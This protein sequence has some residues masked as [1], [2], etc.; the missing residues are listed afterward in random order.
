MGESNLNLSK[1]REMLLSFA[2]VQTM[3]GWVQVCWDSEGAA[4]PME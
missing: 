2:G 4:T 3:A 1:R